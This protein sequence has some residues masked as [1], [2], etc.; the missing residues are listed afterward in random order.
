VTVYR[1]RNCLFDVVRSELTLTADT[2]RVRHFSD[3]QD[4]NAE[5]TYSRDLA[6][7]LLAIWRDIAAN[8]PAIWR[9]E[10]GDEP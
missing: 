1:L 6:E 5:R 4:P 8:S 10:E 3:G 9:V 7:K 2:V